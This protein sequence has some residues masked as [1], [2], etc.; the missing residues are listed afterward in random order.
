MSPGAAGE[1]PGVD[2]VVVRDT[3]SSQ[4]RIRMRERFEEALSFQEF[5][6]SI[7]D[8]THPWREFYHRAR[9]PND[10]LERARELQ[11]RW[12]FL[13]LSEDW[14]GDGANSL[15]YLAR[16]VEAT[17]NLDLRILSRDDNPDLMD[18]HLTGE[19]R[20]IPVV[21]VLDEEFQEVGWWGPRPA[22]LHEIFLRE[23]RPLP[24]ADRYPLLRAWYAKDRGRT[25]LEEILSGIPLSV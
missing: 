19:A 17:P 25:V 14:C 8:H 16:L 9:V 22:P 23:I 11:G 5:L 3:G 2:L 13:V 12:Y 10:L 1:S 20:A 24:K 21:M 15:P 4:E 18:T 7:Q 6:A